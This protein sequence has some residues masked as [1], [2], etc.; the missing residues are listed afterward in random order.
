MKK[1]I[2]IC[3]AATMILVISVA[4]QTKAAQILL[5]D[6]NTNN[7]YAQA[8]L[9]SLSLPY[10]IGNSS[11]FNPLLESGSWDLVIVDCP[12]STPGTGWMPLINYINN[13][14]RTI[15]SFWDL[16]NDSGSG[17]PALAGAFDVGV[18]YSFNAPKNVYR[19]VPGHNIFNTPN[20]VGDLT[21]WTGDDSWID[22]GDAL[23]LVPLSGAQALAGFTTSPVSG[24][25]AIV[26]G[27]SGRTIYNGF[28][29][30]DLNAPVSTN[31]IANEIMY[32]IPE[33]ATIG[34][35]SLGALSL[36]RRKK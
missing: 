3:L 6:N 26:L 15:M 35:L 21:N 18:T 24:E 2:T 17:D 22:N 1:L 9:N 36:L 4:G 11:T 10:T 16:D 20:P 12:G 32:V 28:L 14:G 30:D 27:N 13:N 8:A 33:P 23:A 25:A 34:L 19:W 7:H 29:F 5:F 31:L